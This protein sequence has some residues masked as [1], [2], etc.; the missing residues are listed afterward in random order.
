[1][2]EHLNRATG[3]TV[4]QPASVAVSLTDL[5]A[6]LTL[7]LAQAA[8]YAER[9]GV[10]IIIAL[11]GLDRLS[12]GSNLCWLSSAF[13][14]NV[15]LLA[16]S[17]DGE[18]KD[19]SLARGWVTLSIAP[20]DDS[21]S[22]ALIANMLRLWGKRPLPPRREARILGHSL[23]GLPL[24]LKTILDELRVGATE[25]VLDA[26]LN[27]HLAAEDMLALFNQVLARLERDLGREFVERA[28]SLVWVSRAG[29]DEGD[30][31]YMLK[32]EFGRSLLERTE[33]LHAAGGGWTGEPEVISWS[34]ET[35]LAWAKLRDS[36]SSSLRYQAGR[37]AIDHDFLRHAIEAR[38]LPTV[39]S[40]RRIYSVI[41][42][43]FDERGLNTQQVDLDAAIE[44]YGPNSPS[45]VPY[46]MRTAESHFALG[47]LE[48]ARALEERALTIA[49]STDYRRL[50]ILRN[51]LAGTL[52]TQGE[53]E[54]AQVLLED[55][56][57]LLTEA[58]GRDNPE[59]LLARHHLGE[60]LTSLRCLP[61]AQ[62]LFE[63]AL[64][65]R[66]CVL[67]EQHSETLRTMDAL[68]RV[69]AERG[70][71]GRAREL[72]QRE[73]AILGATDRTGDSG[74]LTT[75]NNFAVTLEACG[76][77]DRAGTLFEFVVEGKRRLHGEAHSDTLTAMTSLA[78]NR[79]RKDD[80]DGAKSLY[81]RVLV[82][83][84]DVLGDD[85]PETLD[86]HDLLA[87]FLL[88]CE[89][90]A[91]AAK[92]FRSL[93]DTLNRK[94]GP[95]DAQTLTARG[96]LA[97]V[98]YRMGDLQAALS[99]QEQLVNVECRVHGTDDP[100]TLLAMNN[101]AEMLFEHGK[102]ESA[103]DLH[104]CVLNTRRRVLEADHNDVKASED[105]VAKAT[106]AL[107]ARR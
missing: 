51:N 34:G 3:E 55:N 77:F 23:A 25:A 17:L 2:L 33:Q 98:M 57:A 73:I 81:E 82:I 65:A 59:T 85:H 61:E 87:H 28:L 13:P 79:F 88:R 102:I 83:K 94:R 38:Y 100:R 92:E 44:Q 12:S 22:R 107:Q 78:G 69:C 21:R 80:L 31:T 14:P 36:L 20:L 67:G 99:L 72:Y 86:A 46:L 15:K 90:L 89:D 96:N 6:R 43:R 5:A 18:A 75:V 48:D 29:L 63:S 105:K 41:P 30:I 26:R 16:S 95:D 104:T 47:A 103:L 11:D 70:D 60:T 93:S 42:R 97:Y 58:L 50:A 9:K 52:Y 7:R 53:Y 68:A 64:E 76:Y 84:Q 1:M 66:L 19:A 71:H 8:R 4:E 37:I 32:H 106:A 62:D 24:F 39:E 49:E 27:D 10:R 91:G 54:R 56:V 35:W 101:L 40:K 45:L 74:F